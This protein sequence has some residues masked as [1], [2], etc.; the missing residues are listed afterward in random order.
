MLYWLLKSEPDVFGYPDLVRVGVEPWNG[1]RNYLAR[2]YLRQ[3]NADDLCLFYHSNAKPNGVAGVAR[4][5]R[6]AY[7]DNLQFDP[8]SAY[9]DPKS[10]PDNPRWSMVDVSPVLVFPTLLTLNALR[11]LPEWADS[12]LTQKGTRL[13]VIPVTAEQFRAALEA[14]GLELERLD[15]AST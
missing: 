13:S 6:A 8:E 3:M 12:P 10:L 1:V 2:N 5:V 11:E 7:T 14:V 9:F 4:V 15:A